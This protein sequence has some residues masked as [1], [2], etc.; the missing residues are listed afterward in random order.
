MAIEIDYVGNIEKMY[1]R[2]V[3]AYQNSFQYDSGFDEDYIEFAKCLTNLNDIMDMVIESRL[4]IN[5]TKLFQ[6]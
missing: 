4:K 1:R 5:D 2:W 6:I 3:A